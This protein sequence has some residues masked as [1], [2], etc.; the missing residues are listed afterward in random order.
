MIFDQLW[1]QVKELPDVAKLQVPGV[2]T[3][4]TKKKLEQKTPEEI[5]LIVSAA[6]DEVNHGSVAPLDELIRKR[7]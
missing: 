3:V 6:I 2:L 1:A 5:E 7:L 4:S